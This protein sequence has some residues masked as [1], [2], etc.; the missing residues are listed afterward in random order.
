MNS[1]N[2][3]E[4]EIKCLQFQKMFVNS[5]NVCKFQKNVQEFKNVQDLENVLEFDF[6]EF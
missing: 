5:N 1:I 4:F 3:H 2:V 6:Y